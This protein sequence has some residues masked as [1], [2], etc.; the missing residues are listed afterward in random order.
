[1]TPH[2][3]RV[4]NRADSYGILIKENDNFSFVAQFTKLPCFKPGG[5]L[6]KPWSQVSSFL[7]HGTGLIFFSHEGYYS[8]AVQHIFIDRQLLLTFTNYIPRFLHF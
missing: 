4:K 3:R 2:F 8:A 7:S 1:M 6:N 5:H